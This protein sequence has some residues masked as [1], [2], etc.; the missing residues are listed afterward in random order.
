MDKDYSLAALLSHCDTMLQKHP[1]TPGRYKNWK[2]AARSVLSPLTEAQKADVRVIDIPAAVE[3]Y[4]GQKQPKPKTKKEYRARVTAAVESFLASIT[5]GEQDLP[6]L[7]EEPSEKV[8]VKIK[9]AVVSEANT[10]TFPIRNDFKAQFILPM[11]LTHEE[12]ERVCNLIKV[13]PLG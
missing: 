3:L 6:A 8:K 5:D 12:A 9:G 4:A 11:D 7:P 10:F 1:D 13:L 2:T